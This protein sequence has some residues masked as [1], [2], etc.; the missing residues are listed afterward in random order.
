M[1]L[2]LRGKSV[3]LI[4]FSNGF[5]TQE[6]LRILIQVVEVKGS[7]KYTV[8]SKKNYFRT[9]S[10]AEKGYLKSDVLPFPASHYISFEFTERTD[11]SDIINRKICQPSKCLFHSKKTY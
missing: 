2:L 6:S 3:T 10:W 11:L 1:R 4:R 5:M 8:Y 7:L 9:L